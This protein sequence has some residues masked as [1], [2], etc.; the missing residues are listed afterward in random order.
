MIASMLPVGALQLEPEP[1]EPPE[2]LEPLVPEPPEP[3][4]VPA[5]P[6]G[7]RRGRRWKRQSSASLVAALPSE[8]VLS[9]TPAP[10]EMDA[11]HP[12]WVDSRK[13]AAS[14]LANKSIGFMCH[15]RFENLFDA[16]GG[17][18]V[19]ASCDKVQGVGVF[20]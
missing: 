3:A 18:F 5:V 2:P 11:T 17:R 16:G 4:P 1:P 12:A 19:T 14:V 8:A 9:S 6:V 10:S 20:G 15:L 7:G 13:L